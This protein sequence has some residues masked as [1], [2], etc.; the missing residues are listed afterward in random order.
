MSFTCFENAA[1]HFQW[2]WGLGYIVRALWGSERPPSFSEGLVTPLSSCGF[3]IVYEF[4][5]WHF[6][7][8][9]NR[10]FLALGLL[11]LHADWNSLW[12]NHPR[13]QELRLLKPFVSREPTKLWVLLSVVHDVK[14]KDEKFRFFRLLASCSWGNENFA[15]QARRASGMK[16]P[17]TPTNQ[18]TPTT[19]WNQSNG[20]DTYRN[21]L[22]L[23]RW[24]N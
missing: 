2:Y 10:L 1:I 4:G 16:W 24:L 9:K 7:H 22:D 14:I 23:S 13:N 21:L 20:D 15:I 18:E 5:I 8:A 19:R 12:P 11:I 6:R 17:D 3:Q